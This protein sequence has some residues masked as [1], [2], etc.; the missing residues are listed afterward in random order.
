MAS[1]SARPEERARRAAFKIALDH[2]KEVQRLV[3]EDLCACDDEVEFERI[4]RKLLNQFEYTDQLR[5]LLRI[6][7]GVERFRTFLRNRS[8]TNFQYSLDRCSSN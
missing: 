2:C 6:E 1:E 3:L 8:G 5:R 4:D 7:G